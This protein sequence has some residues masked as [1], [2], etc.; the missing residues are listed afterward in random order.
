MDK[1]ERE[2]DDKMNH[3]MD[4]IEDV[5]ERG[6]E[7]QEDQLIRLGD[8]VKRVISIIRSKRSKTKE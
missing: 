1:V 2:L 6:G 7:R 3:I 4:A 5:L 8:D